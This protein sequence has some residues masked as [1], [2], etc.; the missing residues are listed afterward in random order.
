M[1]A[2]INMTHDPRYIQTPLGRRTFIMRFC[3]FAF[4]IIMSPEWNVHKDHTHIIKCDSPRLVAVVTNGFI[5]VPE[6]E[7]NEV[8]PSVRL[9]WT[10][11]L[12]EDWESRFFWVLPDFTKYDSYLQFKLFL[13]NPTLAFKK[14]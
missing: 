6:Q 2:S 5:R 9:K 14:D 11:S 4:G 1:H 3:E 8:Q 12:S 13:L 10:T 7:V